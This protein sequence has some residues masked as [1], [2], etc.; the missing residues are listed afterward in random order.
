[1]VNLFDVKAFEYA[2]ECFNAVSKRG[3]NTQQKLVN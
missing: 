3:I 1:M 2:F